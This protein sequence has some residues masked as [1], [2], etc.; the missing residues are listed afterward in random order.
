VTT[1]RHVPSGDELALLM[2][3]TGYRFNRGGVAT[4]RAEPATPEDLA[5]AARLG[6]QVGV[7]ET[8]SAGDI[9][10]RA[11]AAAGTLRS[12]D[13]ARAFVAGVGGSALRG[14]QV[15][16]SYAWARH[17]PVDGDPAECGLRPVEELDVTE[18]LVRLACGWAWNELP[19]HYLVDL[20]AA[21]SQGLPE[22]SDEDRAVL[23]RLLDLVESQPD[24]QTPGGLEKE[25]ARAKLLP[26]TDKY[27]RYGILSALAEAGV[28]PNP[29]LAP[30]WD[31]FVPTSE[32]HEA[33]R[34][35]PGG[36]RSDIVLPLGA[37]RGKDG[38]D[39]Q[40]CAELFSR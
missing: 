28:L 4:G 18:Q 10:A 15:L 21:A 19:A 23:D 29:A 30:S 1:A 17:L 7:R 25:I 35:V 37:W 27:Q 40:R 20:E 8:V 2:R 26:R 14:R 34:H 11:V 9:V 5:E 38:V 36:P 33:S 39:R 24:E 32:R 12:E 6:W 31:R 3:C 13:V 16:I 22:P